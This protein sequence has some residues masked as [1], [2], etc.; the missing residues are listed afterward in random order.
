MY[1]FLIWNSTYFYIR[2]LYICYFPVG[3][4]SVCSGL[5]RAL[6]DRMREPF[7]LPLKICDFCWVG[8]MG[9]VALM[10]IAN[11]AVDV[12]ASFSSYIDKA[13]NHPSL[14]LLWKMTPSS[15]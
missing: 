14:S 13:R 1:N 4:D 9:V 12:A 3:T 15:C 8:E 6:H 10:S 5:V 2:G 7:I 11:M